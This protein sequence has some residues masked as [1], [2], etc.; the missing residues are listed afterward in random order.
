MDRPLGMGEGVASSKPLKI[1][2]RDVWHQHLAG[3]PIG[4]TQ[5]GR[6]RQTFS[7]GNLG[8]VAGLESFL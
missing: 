4:N 5:A 2:Q 6:P 1:T 3:D 7:T 8:F